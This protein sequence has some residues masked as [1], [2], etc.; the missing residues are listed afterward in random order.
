[1]VAGCGG[2]AGGRLHTGRFI[3]PVSLICCGDAGIVARRKTYLSARRR[4]ARDN[5]GD[6]QPDLR[7]S[8]AAGRTGRHTANSNAGTRCGDKNG[9]S[10]PLLN[11]NIRAIAAS[12]RVVIIAGCGAYLGAMKSWP[13]SQSPEDAR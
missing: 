11:T 4:L 3:N 10:V 7:R 1:M 5:A 12:W 8:V 2:N 13:A 9:R 6:I